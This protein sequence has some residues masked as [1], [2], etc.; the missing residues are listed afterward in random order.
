[1]LFSNH[2]MSSIHEEYNQTAEKQKNYIHVLQQNFNQ[3]CQD[4]TRQ[5]IEKLEKTPQSNVEERGKI[6]AEHKA[7]LKQSLNLFKQEIS[8][9]DSATRHKMEELYNQYESSA[10]VQFEKFFTK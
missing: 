3:H 1:V 7:A 4:L 8:S 9:S 2:C 5:A 10:M 6:A